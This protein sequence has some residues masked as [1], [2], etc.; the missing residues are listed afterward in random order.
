MI[1][2]PRARPAVAALAIGVIA[3]VV[4]NKVAAPPEAAPSAD[5]R[6]VEEPRLTDRTRLAM[7]EEERSARNEQ[8]FGQLETQK[9]KMGV[10]ILAKGETGAAAPRRPPAPAL[11]A[12]VPT[13]LSRAKTTEAGAAAISKPSAGLGR[14]A[15][16]AAL[17]FTDAS[18]VASSWVLLG[19]PGDPPA[20]DFANGRLVIIKP[21]ATKILSVTPG[22]D[23]V[24]V[25][26]RSLL[27]E[28]RPDP[29]RE[30]AAPLPAAP[31]AVLIYDASPR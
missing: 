3:L 11:D 1:L 7:T 31:K 13:L 24:T 30:R 9:K 10:T 18:G 19:L 29:A 20:T 6:P 17:V 27:P 5:V 2:P 15:P 28:E 23:A 16:D 4:W 14:S 21:S 25:V 22:R 8:M 12:P 26:Y